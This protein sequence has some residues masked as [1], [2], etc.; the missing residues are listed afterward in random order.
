MKL[1]SER[2]AES[3]AVFPERSAAVRGDGFRVGWGTHRASDV[4]GDQLRLE[5]DDPYSEAV[6]ER[7]RD[8]VALEIGRVVGADRVV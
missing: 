8:G 7:P 2:I 1:R 4:R 3:A 6:M 5:C